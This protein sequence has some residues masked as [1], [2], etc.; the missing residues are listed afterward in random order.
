MGIPVDDIAAPAGDSFKFEKL[1][2]TIEGEIVF[3]GDFEERV[4]K[5]TNKNEK[6]ARIGI[7]TGN[8]EI[9][10]IWPVQGSPMGRALADA[11]RQ[12]GVTELDTGQHIKL[13]HHETKDTGKP[14]PLKL[15]RARIT[16]AA[17]AI[18]VPDDED[19]F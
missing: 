5:F 3:V 7:D 18:T 4:N 2:D 9:M 10:Y 16:A 12:A 13:A 17:P 1:G 19:L 8:G 14:Q 6:V 11:L 15:Y